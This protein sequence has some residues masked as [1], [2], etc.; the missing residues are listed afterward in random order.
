[1]NTIISLARIG[2]IP[3]IFS[4]ILYLIFNSEKFKNVKNIYKQLIAGL[5]FGGIAIVG[6]EFGATSKRRYRRY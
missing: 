1:M 6:T 5:I 4:V 3:V 2:V